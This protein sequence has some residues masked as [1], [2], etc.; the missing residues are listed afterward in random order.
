MQLK[1]PPRMLQVAKYYHVYAKGTCPY[2]VE[3]INL[4]D[5][6]GFNYTLT[7]LDK[8]SNVLEHLKA[9]HEWRTVPIIL[10]YDDDNHEEFKLIGGY[11]DIVE[12]LTEDVPVPAPDTFC[13]IFGLEDADTTEN[14]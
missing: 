2:C 7:L 5:A 12:H 11:S 8:N 9:K 3:A 1:A 14:S 13:E 10:E 4:L 6:G